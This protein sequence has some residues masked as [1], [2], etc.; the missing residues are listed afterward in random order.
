[1]ARI[2]NTS[3][4]PNIGTPVAS[5]YLILTDKSDNLVTKTATLGDVQKLFGLDTLVAKVTVNSASLLSSF[6]NPVTLIANPGAEK[7]FDIMD[8]MVSFEAGSAVY[9]FANNVN[10]FAG[11]SPLYTINKGTLNSATSSVQK[12]HLNASG[13]TQITVPKGVPF[14]LTTSGSNPTQGSGTLYLNI[15]YRVL[16]VGS[17]F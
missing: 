7:V 5:D 14:T 6:S 8:V 11:T 3:A 1:M 9:D 12:L 4:Y 10:L 13:G 15:Y 2:S 16:T 17:S